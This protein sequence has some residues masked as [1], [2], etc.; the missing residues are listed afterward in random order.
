MTP[1]AHLKMKEAAAF[2]GVH[3]DTFR[4]GW[5]EMVRDE[6]LPA[7]FRPRPYLWRREDLVAWQ[8][9]RVRELRELALAGRPSAANEDAGALRPPVPRAGRMAHLQ[10]RA[11]QRMGGAR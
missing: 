4:K 1:S 8:E 5:R 2:C 6:G 9:R 11:L 3:Y 10:A 7:P